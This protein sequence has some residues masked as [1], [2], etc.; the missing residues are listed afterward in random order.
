VTTSLSGLRQA[1][2]GLA[3][4]SCNGAANPIYV[5]EG[6]KKGCSYRFYGYSGNDQL[7]EIY[8]EKIASRFVTFQ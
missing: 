1:H 8:T 6:L 5:G 7:L 3:R 2:S 4:S